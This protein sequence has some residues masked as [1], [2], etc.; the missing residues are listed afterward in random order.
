MAAPVPTAP[1]VATNPAPA[2]ATA[3][4]RAQAPTPTTAVSRL[5]ALG[6][7]PAPTAARTL[8]DGFK[9]AYDASDHNPTVNYVAHGVTYQGLNTAVLRQMI[10]D[11]NLTYQD[12]LVILTCLA[13]AGNN[14][15]RLTDRAKVTDERI[16]RAAYDIIRK[17]G[18]TGM[19]SRDNATLTMSRVGIAFLP[20]YWKLRVYLH[21]TGRL[22][23]QFPGTIDVVYQDPNMGALAVL[24]GLETQYREY[25][26]QFTDALAGTGPSGKKRSNTDW[27]M[28]ACRGLQQD[29]GSLHVLGAVSTLEL[30]PAEMEPF[31]EEYRN[32]TFSTA[33]VTAVLPRTRLVAQVQRPES[34]T[35][36]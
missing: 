22:Q 17:A 20:L 36:T 16:A 15:Q 23:E 31:F 11:A 5:R 34:K 28:V 33:P 30:S 29:I 18:I 1:I 12:L 19:K 27:L 10:W 35:E 32:L 25:E 6:S 9:E 7:I 13:I 24:H 26:K 8:Y 14:P 4:A 2:A 21:A 3:P